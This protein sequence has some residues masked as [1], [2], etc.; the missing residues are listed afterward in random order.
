M[1][2]KNRLII[3]FLQK[4]TRLY[5]EYLPVKDEFVEPEL[6]V[7]CGIWKKSHELP[8]WRRGPVIRIGKRHMKYEVR[9]WVDV[10]VGKREYEWGGKIQCSNVIETSRHKLPGDLKNGDLVWNRS[11]RKKLRRWRLG[12]IKPIY[13]LPTWLAFYKFDTGLGWKT[14]YSDNIFEHNAIFS[15]VFFGLHITFKTIAPC[16]N[17]NYDVTQ[18]FRYG[19][20]DEYWESVL[21]RQSC[22]SFQEFVDTYLSFARTTIN[23]PLN[24][25]KWERLSEESKQYKYGTPEY[26]EIHKKMLKYRGIDVAWFRL[27][28]KWLVQQEHI[29][30]FKTKTTEIKNRKDNNKYYWI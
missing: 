18:N 8:V 5:N 12:W 9:N 3:S 6:H 26:E 19:Y 4:Y 14:K 21:D 17:S 15:L 23:N 28:E 30:I 27:S 1:R 16:L 20:D 24:R 25:G 7:S 22:K 29:D 10:V 2:I 13:I 11:I